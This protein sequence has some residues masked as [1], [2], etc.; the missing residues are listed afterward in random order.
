[1]TRTSKSCFAVAFAALCVAQAVRADVVRVVDCVRDSELDVWAAPDVR[2]AHEVMEEVFKTAGLEPAWGKPGSD[3]SL[4]G[5]DVDVICSAFRTPELL[6]KFDFPLQPMSVMH[7]ALYAEPN[8]SKEMISTKISE[9]PSM[10]V[11]YSPVSQGQSGDRTNYFEHVRLSPDYV[12]FP[13]SADAVQALHK[14]GVDVLFLYTPYN[15]RPKGIVEVVPI[16]ARNAY[17]AVRKG[18]PELLARLTKAYRD[19]YIDKIDKVDE[20][21]ARHFGIQKPANRVRVAAYS[22]GD[23][24]SVSPDGDHSGDL[25]TWLKAVSSTAK[26]ELDYV[27]GGYEESVADVKAGRLDIIGG[28]SF[29]V[30][31]RGSFL[32]PH[33]PIGMLRVYLWTHKSLP[34]EPGSPQTWRGM[35]VGLLT[36]TVSAQRVRKQLEA[37]SLG[38]SFREY[39][40]D[41]EMLRAYF[42]GEIDAC[43]DVEMPELA[44]ET[45]LHLCVAHPMY[46]CVALD[47]T[48]IFASL[49][50]ALDELC[51][52]LPKYMR[53]IR[54]HHYG[55]RSE[56]ATLTLKESE[57]LNSWLKTGK[58]VYVDFS[59]WPFAIRDKSGHALGLALLLQSEV[60]RRTGLEILPQEQTGVYTAQAKFMRGETMFWIPYPAKVEDATFGAKSVFSIP[61]PSMVA[62]FYGAEDDM[63]EFEM[64]ANP[65]APPELVSILKK[66]VTGIDA[67]RLQEMFV[68]AA[69]ER[70]VVHK[71]FGLTSDQLLKVIVLVVVMVML[72][73]VAYS[74][75]MVRLLKREAKKSND[76]AAAAEEHAMAKTRFLAMMSHELRTPLNA[77][78]GFAEFMSR[79]DVDSDR[80]REYTDGIL[81]SANALLDLIN[82]IL[83]L[84]KLE[85]GATD[86]RAGE[87]DIKKLLAELPAIFGYRI[88]RHGV[89]LEVTAESGIPV[90]AL[91][92][93]GMRQI[94]INLVG[95]AAK[96]TKT[97]TISVKAAWR[98][99]DNA[100]HIEV[101]DT[102]CGISDEKMAKLFD[103]FVQDIAS[104]MERKDGDAKGTGLGLPIVKR[105]VDNAHGTVTAKSSLGNGTVFCIDIPGLEVVG[106]SPTVHGT[107]EAVLSTLPR[108]VLVVDDMDTNRRILSIHLKNLD[109]EE[110]RTAENG[111]DAL[112]MMAG[113]VPDVVLTDMWMPKM[114]GAQLAEAMRADRRLADVPIVAVTADVDVGSTFDMSLFAKV[115]AKPVTTEKLQGLFGEIVR[116]S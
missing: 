50:N 47:K 39:S 67:V 74:M 115:L 23:I 40:S 28:L 112:A 110:V 30:T 20:L 44:H 10:R 106:H 97:G 109:I 52:D 57:W 76:A 11:G 5:D 89:K 46:I 98:S 53:M 36:G 15:R 1:M 64:F 8:R 7:F 24:F 38:L 21:R 18:K 14:G 33:T 70:K 19:F 68:S 35:K 114:D 13:R 82:D 105:M 42:G 43:V 78:I 62:E 84:S 71:V 3:A 96:F 75:Y 60:K 81:T 55:S 56:M 12:E 107:V 95:N 32:F 83:D 116:E 26:W 79:K 113:W 91:S 72:A 90:V 85:A 103:P 22:R 59:P 111:E 31:R 73:I 25:E 49:E 93:Q 100:L 34:Y 54:D 17:F 37:E 66:A 29:D 86:M 2:Y 99:G 51:D 16:G 48:E 58:P 45:A 88:R 104:R 41:R 6:K 101:A 65:S 94:L 69:A 77:V 102:G 80:R 87:C 27:Y 92:Q 63:Q 9:W 61:V 108:Q 4:P